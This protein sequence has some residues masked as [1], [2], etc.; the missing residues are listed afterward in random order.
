MTDCSVAWNQTL[1]IHGWLLKFPRWL[2]PIFARKSKAVHLEVRSSFE[3]G[4]M[5]GRGELVEMMDSP[6]RIPNTSFKVLLS[7]VDNQRT[8]L[9][10]KA[11]HSKSGQVA[12]HAAGSTEQVYQNQSKAF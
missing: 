7:A 3:S 10:L 9:E 4:P 1:T 5:L 6:S 8:S 11:R 12:D 2:M